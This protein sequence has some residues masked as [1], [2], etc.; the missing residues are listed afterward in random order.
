MGESNSKVS[1]CDDLGERE[2]G[3]F[4]IK[5]AADNLEVWGESAEV[6]VDVLAGQ[7]TET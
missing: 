5:V 7:I 6:L 2:V 1:V 4:E 3:G